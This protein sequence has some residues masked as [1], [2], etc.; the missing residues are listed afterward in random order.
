[1]TILILMQLLSSN[2]SLHALHPYSYCRL[3]NETLSCDLICFSSFHFSPEI[4][5]HRAQKYLS[6]LLSNQTWFCS[7]F[8]GCVC[9]C[10]IC[11]AYP[12]L[13]FLAKQSTKRIW[14]TQQQEP[15]YLMELKWRVYKFSLA[16]NLF[17]NI[18]EKYCFS[19]TISLNSHIKYAVCCSPHLTT[20]TVIHI[21]TLQPVM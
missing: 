6:H 12:S 9:V 1:M 3:S 5:R 16:K 11:L 8:C 7:W 17:W 10:K 4:I 20:H 15:W 13:N 19:I 18:H 14:M 2:I 21:H